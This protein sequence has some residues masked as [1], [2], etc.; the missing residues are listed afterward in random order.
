MPNVVLDAMIKRADFAQE[1]EDKS[2]ELFDK[3]DIT[4][5]Q[6]KA[7]VINMLRKPD[8]QRE[9]NHWSPD[10]IAEF[11]QSFANG[12]LIPSLILWKSNSH[13]FV[14]DGGHR[15]S[16]LRAWVEN[17]YGDGPISQ[18]F[19]GTDLPTAQKA[20]AKQARQKV[21]AVVGRFTDVAAALDNEGTDPALKKLASTTFTRAI[22]VQWIQGSQEVAEVSFFKINSQ[23]TPLDE[24]EELILKNRKKSYAIAARALVRAGTGNK[25]W[26][27]FD[28]P[29]RA[30]IEMDANELYQLLF[31]PD[32]SMPVKTLDLPLGGSVSPVEAF[33]LL[34]DMY[35][36]VDG[37]GRVEK[38][39]E[40][41]PDDVT[42]QHTIGV[43]T[44]TGKLIRRMTGNSPG[45]LGL[46][47]AVYFYNEK[48]RHS[49]FLFLG[50]VG[51]L[52]EPLRNNNKQFFADFTKVR[53]EFEKILISQKGLINQGLANVNSKQ[54]IDRVTEMLQG[55]ADDLQHS[56]RVDGSRVLFHLGLK[57]R[58]AEIQQLKYPENFSLDTKS[59]TFI[60][61]SIKGAPRCPICKGLLDPPKSISYD[62]KLRKQDGGD[63]APEN[64]QMT[65]PYCNTGVKN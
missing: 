51:F 55:I 6:P 43:L 54:R 49:R 5:I 38:Y 1:T 47:P 35:A 25:Y 4:K 34:L 63:G 32:L 28:E 65:H 10:Q 33:K 44:R 41:L 12:Q 36:L 13:V 57:G 61:D 52:A 15:L 18:A 21:E 7:P 29:T 23:G 64:A 42:G 46:Q 24:V 19:F 14:I 48:G 60:A 16:A 30:K 26:S 50:T 2:I 39:I 45:S 3:F 40:T 11:I 62:H 56:K 37:N 17:D 31:Q 22:P 53:G 9:T 20:A 58:V 8:F 27:G 59:A